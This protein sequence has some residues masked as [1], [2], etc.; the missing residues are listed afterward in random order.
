VHSSKVSYISGICLAV[1]FLILAFFVRTSNLD[2]KFYW[3]DEVSSS[4]VITGHWPEFFETETNKITGQI[5][6]IGEYQKIFEANPNLSTGRLVSDLMVRDPHHSPLYFILTQKW[7]GIFGA[8]P[9]SLRLSSALL[10]FIGI[11][12]F[13]WLCVELFGSLLFGLV[14]LSVISLAPFHILFSQQN[15]DYGLWFTT[16]ALSTVLLLIANRTDQKRYWFAYGISVALSLYT[17]LFSLLF[18]CSHFVFQWLEKNSAQDS[19]FKKYL[20]ASAFGFVLYIPWMVNIF[21]KRREV[22]DLNSWSSGY[23]E[24]KIY[25]QGL[26]LNFSRLFVDFNLPSFKP[27]PWDNIFL[28]GSILTVTVMIFFSVII[29]AKFLSRSKS[30]LVISALVIPLLFLIFLDILNGQGIHVLVGRQ[31]M[32]AWMAVYLSVTFA[33]GLGFKSNSLSKK[34]AA[35]SSSATLLILGALFLNSYPT[36]K[37]WWPLKSGGLFEAATQIEASNSDILITS[38][39]VSPKHFLSMSYSLRRDFPLLILKDHS[40]IS[41]FDKINAIALYRPSD[42]MK[43]SFETNFELQKLSDNLWIGM[44]KNN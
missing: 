29:V 33:I 27:L 42:W 10:S 13:A 4:F 3:I 8:S 43:A 20:T 25:L 7:A 14:G 38:S 35:M 16:C 5:V 22:E 31:L 37:I 15:R 32:P 40:S 39:S 44:R 11:P 41:N 18:L 23:I 21:L 19:R 1:I 24:P 26:I 12:I 30:S 34:F 28:I 2:K 9:E 6:S 17:F 36:Q